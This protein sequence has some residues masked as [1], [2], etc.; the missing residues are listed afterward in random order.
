MVTEEHRDHLDY[1]LTVWPGP[2]PSD[3]AKHPGLARELARQAEAETVVMD[4]YKDVALKLSEDETGAALNQAIQLMVTDGIEV[5]GV[6]HTKKPEKGQGPSLELVYGSTWLTAGIGSLVMLWGAPGDL[7]VK[8]HHLKQPAGEVGPLELIHDPTTGRTTVHTEVTI[9]P[10]DAVMATG[11]E[12]MLV[13]DVAKVLY[14]GRDITPN[15]VEKSRRQ[16]EALRSE[17]KLVR[18]EEGTGVT[19][20]YRYFTPEA[21]P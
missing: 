21:A 10:L 11:A 14:R 6:H 16:L 8:L 2:P 18:V 7:V 4:S 5:V 9:N 20:R 17:G 15:L 12:G 13:S 19:R 3:L 1:W